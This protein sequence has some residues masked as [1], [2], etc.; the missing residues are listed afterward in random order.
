MG[1]LPRR[2][3]AAVLVAVAMSL[4]PAAAQDSRVSVQELEEPGLNGVDDSAVVI[5][6]R[7]K[8]GAGK[9]GD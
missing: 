4:F 1:I 5:R 7:I 3:F 2:L 6:A 8:A 9:D